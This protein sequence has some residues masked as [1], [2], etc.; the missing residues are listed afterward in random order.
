ME[1]D[2]ELVAAVEFLRRRLGD[3]MAVID[4]WEADFEA[5]GIARRDNEQRL[6][7]LS[8]SP[9]P[10]GARFYV[11]LENP[12]APGSDLPYTDAGHHADLSLAEA[13]DLV[14][15]HLGLP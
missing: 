9:A 13:A 14:A 7:Y 11:A 5:V 8:V 10:G 1:K 3:K 2:S 15:R 6:A 12:P 4:H